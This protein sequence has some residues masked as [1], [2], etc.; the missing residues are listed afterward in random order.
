MILFNTQNAISNA[1][2]PQVAIFHSPVGTD[3]KGKN[4]K[5]LEDAFAVASAFP[6]QA[7]FYRALGVIPMCIFGMN[8]L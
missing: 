8:L 7:T 1:K 3:C 5:H 2:K 4:E 6:V